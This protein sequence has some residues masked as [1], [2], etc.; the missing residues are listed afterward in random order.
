[1]NS[2]PEDPDY[3]ARLKVALKAFDNGL[4]IFCTTTQKLYTP[5][6]FVESGEKVIITKHGL[7]EYSNCVL[8]Y[9]KDAIGRKLED[10][11][12]AQKDFDSFMEM[13]MTAFDLHP[14]KAFK[15]KAK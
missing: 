11:H 12:K 9:P 8:H 14:V 5:R 4:V 13:M 15:K 2:K 7:D 1:M 6:T 3:E 10:L